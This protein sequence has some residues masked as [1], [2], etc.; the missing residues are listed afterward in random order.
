MPTYRITKPYTAKSR[1]IIFN[2][3]MVRAI[4]KGSKTQTRRILRPQPVTPEAHVVVKK[5]K[6]VIYER[7]GKQP[8]LGDINATL[9]FPLLYG[10]KGDFL[11]VRETIR[12]RDVGLQGNLYGATYVADLTPVVGQGAQGSFCGRAVC[13][14][15]WKRDTLSSIHTPRWASRI[16]L[17]ITEIRVEQI[18][19]LSREDFLAEGIPQFTMARGILSDDPPDP[20]WK[21]IELWDSINAKKGYGW[22]SNPWVFIISFQKVD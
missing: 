17:K 19:Q 16:T 21:F 22:E 1:P 4:L 8:G 7:A 12:K 10:Q 9:S 11:W 14:W 2:A 6:L 3:E 15:K 20:R 18:Q 5:D 13:D